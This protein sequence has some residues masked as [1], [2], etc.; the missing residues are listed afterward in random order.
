MEKVDKH[1]Y[2]NVDSIKPEVSISINCYGLPEEKNIQPIK[3][4]RERDER[5][6]YSYMN[7]M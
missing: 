2:G 1:T 6:C 4:I 5:N 7:S 3:E